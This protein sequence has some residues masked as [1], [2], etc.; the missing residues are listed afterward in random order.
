M[1]SPDAGKSIDGID[2]T[3]GAD[4][5]LLS[6]PVSVLQVKLS[7]FGGFSVTMKRSSYAIR[8]GRWAGSQSSRPAR[9]CHCGE[10]RRQAPVARFHAILV[11]ARLMAD[12]PTL[13]R[14]G[15]ARAIVPQQPRGSRPPPAR[16]AVAREGSG[17]S[18]SRW[19]ARTSE[20][21]LGRNWRPAPARRRTAGASAQTPP[22]VR[23]EK[24]IGAASE[25]PGGHPVSA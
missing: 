24:Q 13:C 20:P 14:T 15:C 10:L 19:P 23:F 18:V 5:L 25:A 17:R 1:N 6:E 7:S 12:L 16:G 2:Q 9:R 4:P 21:A 8:S 11:S 22:P 3:G